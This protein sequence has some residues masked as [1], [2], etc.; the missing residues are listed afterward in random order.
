M[1]TIINKTASSWYKPNLKEGKLKMGSE[2]LG[3]LEKGAPT[4]SAIKR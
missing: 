4:S 2:I 1:H 3:Y